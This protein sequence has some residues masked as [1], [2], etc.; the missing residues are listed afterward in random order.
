MNT[1]AFHPSGT[2]FASGS[3]DKT[4]KLFDLRTHTLIQHYSDAHVTSLASSSSPAIGGVNSINFGGNA[5]EWLISTGIDGLV[6]VT[7]YSM[8]LNRRF[9][10]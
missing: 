2:V 3:V 5:A 10:T 4:I 6:K 8:R 9:G 7:L 1:V